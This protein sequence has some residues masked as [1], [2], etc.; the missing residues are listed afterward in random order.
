M[1]AS[2]IRAKKKRTEELRHWIPREDQDK[3]TVLW[4]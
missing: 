1:K 4:I 2:E 3:K